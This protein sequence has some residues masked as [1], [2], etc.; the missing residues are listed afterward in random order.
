LPDDL[1]RRVLAAV[2]VHAAEGVLPPDTATVGLGSA[3][4]ASLRATRN[5]AEPSQ[6]VDRPPAT[7]DADARRLAPLLSPLIALLWAHRSGEAPWTRVMSGTIASA[8]FGARHLWQD[9]GATGRPEVTAL[10]ERHFPA[11]A[12]RNV[13][14]LKWKNHLF[15]CLGA[16]LGIPDLR[17]PR[18]DGCGEQPVCFPERTVVFRRPHG[19]PAA[20][21]EER[22]A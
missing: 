22:P 3:E 21:E 15:R 12:A 14:N 5:V 2:L 4:F 17:P 19:D 8:A 1:E 9:L 6:P 20:Q 13:H 10:M 18:C 16:E 11:L 7:D